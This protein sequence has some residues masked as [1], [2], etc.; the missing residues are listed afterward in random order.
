MVVGLTGFYMLYRFD[1]WDRF[2]YAAYWWLDAMLAVW[3]IFTTMLFVIEPLALDQW[4]LAR[5]GLKAEATFK[6]IE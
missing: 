3:L 2:R 6:A 4:L 5:S 1:I